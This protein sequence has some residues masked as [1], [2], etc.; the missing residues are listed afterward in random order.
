MG[1]FV[2]FVISN[3]GLIVCLLTAALWIRFRP[4]SRAARRFLLAV[5]AAYT[6]ASIYVIPYTLS[7]ALVV[8][9]RPI[10]AGDLPAGRTAIVV[11]SAGGGSVDD[12]DRRRFFFL[13]RA[14]AS[15]TW[16]ARRGY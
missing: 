3:G 16:E 8:G 2:G 10:S 15:R 11:L 13:G 4:A 5:V 9:Y 7:R 1:W 12:W 14:G 6:L